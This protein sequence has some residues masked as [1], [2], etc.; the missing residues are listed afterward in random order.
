MCSSSI[1][2]LHHSREQLDSLVRLGYFFSRLETFVDSVCDR[3]AGAGHLYHAALASGVEELLDV[4]RNA[5]LQ[6]EQRLLRPPA[7]P[8]LALRHFLTDFES[9][10]PEIANIVHEVQQRRLNAAQIMRLLDRRT[11]CGIPAVQACAG[12]L[13]W[14]CHQ[15]MF[16]QLESWMVYGILVDPGRDFFIQTNKPA[17]ETENAG[18]LTTLDGYFVAEQVLPPAVPAAVAEAVLFV[19]RSIRI[20]RHSLPSAAAGGSPVDV[21]AEVAAFSRKLRELQQEETLRPA[22]LRFAVETVQGKVAG[23]LWELLRQKCDLDGQLAALQAYFLLGRGDLYQQLLQDAAELLKTAPAPETANGDWEQ[24]FSQAAI[25]SAAE[26]DPFF[27]TFKLRW[28]DAAAPAETMPAWHPA[29]NPSLYVPAYD[30]WDGL[31]LECTAQWPMHL[32]LPVDILQKYCA[33]W[34]LIFRLRRAQMDLEKAWAALVVLD[35]PAQRVGRRSSST[36]G[37]TTRLPRSLLTQLGQLRQRM[38]HFATNLA[39][40]LRVDVAEA[41]AA[42]LRNSIANSQDFTRA[43]AAHHAFVDT[44]TSQAC[45]DIRQLMAAVESIFELS[46]TLSAVVNALENGRTNA[47]VATGQVGELAASFRLKHNVVVQLLQSNQLQT[48]P[49]AA[50]LRQLVVRLNFNHFAENDVLQGVAAEAA[51]RL[52]EDTAYMHDLHI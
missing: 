28:F 49:R 40:Y 50:G 48:G 6:V 39:V 11:R 14:H 52:S 26:S 42:V 9:L 19:G 17:D 16:K 44:L 25:N 2:T 27:S 37:A 41:A 30:E 45:L 20:L 23:L 33:V 21:D 51:A 10:L 18:D 32:L 7:P 36:G 43:D 3:A 35:R 47:E 1:V 38:S 22:A 15:V 8:L 5:V 4:Y 31:C 12:R 34:Q 24:A 13:L 29:R 46:R